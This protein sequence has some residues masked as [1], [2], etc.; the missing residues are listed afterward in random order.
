MSLC[1]L[2][3]YS[4]K[5]TEAYDVAIQKIATSPSFKDVAVNEFIKFVT[6]EIQSLLSFN[7]CGSDI[8]TIY[9]KLNTPSKETTVLCRD[10]HFILDEYQSYREG[11]ATFLNSLKYSDDFNKLSTFLD[12]VINR[13][14]NFIDE[15]YSDENNPER[16]IPLSEAVKYVDFLVSIA[17]NKEDYYSDVKSTMVSLSVL[18]PVIKEKAAIIY[19]ECIVRFLY[20]IIMESFHVLEKLLSDIKP[21]DVLSGVQRNNSFLKLKMF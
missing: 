14:R 9:A 10:I 2:H 8:R 3:Q 1:T 13:S 5:I 20:R 6:E 18:Q 19:C 17:K 11:M 16:E 15:L 4:E 21:V 12:G 7:N